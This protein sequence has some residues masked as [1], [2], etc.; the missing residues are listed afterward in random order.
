MGWRMINFRELSL[1]WELVLRRKRG[2][3]AQGSECLS[4]GADPKGSHCNGREPPAGA[5]SDR[6]G[7]DE[8]SR[9]RQASY[10]CH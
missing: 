10:P 4:A 9:A 7:R 3:L 6:I 8:Y 5:E 2:H 1:L